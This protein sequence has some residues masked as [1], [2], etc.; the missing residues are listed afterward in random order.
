MTKEIGG[1]FPLELGCIGNFPHSGGVLV[2]SG[3]NALEFILRSLKQV[4]KVYVPHFTCEV[5]LEPFEKLGIAYEFYSIG[6]QL[7]LIGKYNLQEHEYLIYTNYF[8]IKDSYVASLEKCL[9]GCLIVDCAQALYAQPAAKCFYSPRKFVGIPDGGLAFTDSEASDFTMEE[10]QSYGLCSHL[11]KRID[12]GRSGAYAEFKANGKHL[13]HQPIQKISAL[14]HRLLDSID[15]DRIAQKRKSN[16][17]YL[18]AHLSMSNQLSIPELDSFACP[19]VYPYYVENDELR[20]T[21][22]NHKIY[23]ATYW[24]NVLDWCEENT[25]E[26]NLAKYILPLPVDQRYSTED[27]NRIIEIIKGKEYV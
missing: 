7:E 26:Y 15:F 20:K 3:R 5:V 12:C 18:H 14:T 6:S 9:G 2:N 11:L 24:P 23:V 8:G 13:G 19:M 25:T 21:L 4:R 27:M 16:F 10:S 17:E 22:I 1:Y